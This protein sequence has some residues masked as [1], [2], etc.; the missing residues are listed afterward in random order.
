MTQHMLDVLRTQPVRVQMS[1]WRYTDSDVAEPL[2]SDE[3]IFYPPLNE[4]V[5]LR[6]KL[7][8]LSRQSFHLVV[9]FL[10]MPFVS[11]VTFNVDR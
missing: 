10:L 9:F 8:N 7:T 5:C 4:F 11:S 3:G 2:S 1:L 6:V